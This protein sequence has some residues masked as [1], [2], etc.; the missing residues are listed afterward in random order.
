[1]SNPFRERERENTL[2]I[3]FVTYGTEQQQQQ[4]AETILWEMG[5]KGH[6]VVSAVL[7]GDEIG[8]PERKP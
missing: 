2:V 5:V 8:I 4:T 1:M 7:N 3:H 6:N